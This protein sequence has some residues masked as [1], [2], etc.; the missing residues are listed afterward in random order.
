MT[1]RLFVACTSGLEAPL[2][3]ELTELGL[4]ATMTTGGCFADAPELIDVAR[5]NLHSRIASRV[6]WLLGK[7]SSPRGLA[8]IPLRQ[9]IGDAPANLQV[10]TRGKVVPPPEVWRTEATRL[11]GLGVG[12]LAV[13]LQLDGPNA[14]LWC[15]TSG[16]LLYRR[17]ARQETGKAPLRETLAS[18]VLRLAGWKPGE[19]LWDVMCGSGT[20]LIEAAEQAQGFRAGRARAFPFEPFP[21]FEAS[22]IQALRAAGPRVPTWFMG[23][24]LNAGALG[25]A[26]RNSKRAGVF[27]ALKLE[28]IDAT[29]L[30]K[31]AGA[32]ETGLVIAN[33]PYGKRVGQ[34]FELDDLY[35]ALGAQLPQSLPG[36]RFA[37]LLQDGEDAL[38]L[39]IA[40]VADVSNG[41]LSC[42][43]VMGTIGA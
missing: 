10:S 14:E 5:V 34:R 29:K 41:G 21:G 2:R 18:G 27:E 31:P 40:E 13:S 9:R 8:A 28:R 23:S 35:R 19:P 4:L 24:D 6:S 42:Q 32:P 16:E 30:S 17:G 3:D 11:Y 22:A 37:F 15:D 38:G 25:I 33:L 7:A 36:W 43:V 1:E 12:S 39:P 20:I 26:R